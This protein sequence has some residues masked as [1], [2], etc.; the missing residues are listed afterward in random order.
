MISSRKK[1][2]LNPK[3]KGRFPNLYYLF[4]VIYEINKINQRNEDACTLGQ[5]SMKIA[6]MEFPRL[7][8]A[9]YPAS[10]KQIIYNEIFSANFSNYTPSYHRIYS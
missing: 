4:M 2:F 5:T 9:K 7:P 10:D 6:N 8:G 1:D 3:D